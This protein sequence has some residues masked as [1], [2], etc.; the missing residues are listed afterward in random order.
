[1]RKPRG[2]FGVVFL[3]A[4]LSAALDRI[5]ERAADVRRA[6]TPG[7]LPVRGDVATDAPRERFTLDPLSVSAPDAAYFVVAGEHGARAFTRDGSFR[8]VDGRLV[9]ESGRAVLGRRRPDGP[10]EELRVDPVDAA[11]GRVGD[12]RVED[13]GTVTYARSSV[14]PRSGRRSSA[15]VAIGRVALARFP[16]STALESNDGQAFTAPSGAIAHVG[17]PGDTAFGTLAPH[18]REE[19]RVDIDRSLER[20]KDAYVAF[21]ALA[22]AEAAR[23]RFGKT[24]MDVVK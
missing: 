23:G 12:A 17:V 24:V 20:L 10:L 7:A 18:R 2:G 22:A 11:L 1:M 14:D 16:A 19:S 21:D 5:A 8:F 13:D 3:N 4:G 6:F 15:G 9:T